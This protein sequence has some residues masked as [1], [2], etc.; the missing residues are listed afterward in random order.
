[1]FDTK[2]ISEAKEASVAHAAEMAHRDVERERQEEK[3]EMVRGERSLEIFKLW[4]AFTQTDEYRQFV[5]SLLTM[6]CDCLHVRKRHLEF[7]PNDK[8]HPFITAWITG[9]Y[10]AQR[11]ATPHSLE[12]YFSSIAN[13]KESPQETFDRLLRDLDEAFERERHSYRYRNDTDYRAAYDQQEDEKRRLENR[14]VLMVTLVVL[15]F[16]ATLVY[17]LFLK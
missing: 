4:T 6:K 10:H 8:K 16:M 17:Y 7:Y 5:A 9:G 15:A 13:L 2:G 3:R 14:K 1:M 11:V 12:G